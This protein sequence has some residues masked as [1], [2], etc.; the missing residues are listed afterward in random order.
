MAIAGAL[1]HSL[2]TGDIVIGE[3]VCDLNNPGEYYSSDTHLLETAKFA[4]QHTNY[5]CGD[6]ITAPRVIVSIREKRDIH[7]KTGALAVDMETSVAASWAAHAG[8]PFL[9][10]RTISDTA[11]H[12]LGQGLLRTAATLVTIPWGIWKATQ[13]LEPLANQLISNL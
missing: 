12:G 9:T 11:G 3:R 2:K 4:Y 8:I 6:L 7:Q 5:V 1:D 13:K 10:I